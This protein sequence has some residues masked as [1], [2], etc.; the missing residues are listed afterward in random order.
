[1]PPLWYMSIFLAGST[2]AEDVAAFPELYAAKR[3]WLD[4][5]WAG[6]MFAAKS[7]D[8]ISALRMSEWHAKFEFDLLLAASGREFGSLY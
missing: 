6:E 1:M 8:D 4:R 7:R 5:D 3:A 2:Y